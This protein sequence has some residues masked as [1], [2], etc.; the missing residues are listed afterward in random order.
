[1]RLI[2][3][4]MLRLLARPGWLFL[5]LCSSSIMAADEAP[6]LVFETPE[7]VVLA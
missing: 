5:V 1:M 7:D 4:P 2:R 3:L 6:P